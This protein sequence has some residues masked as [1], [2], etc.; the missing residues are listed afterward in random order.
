MWTLRLVGVILALS[1]SAGEASQLTGALKPVTRITL[2]PG[3]TQV[4]FRSGEP[5]ATWGW[6]RIVTV[7][8]YRS[9]QPILREFDLHAGGVST[10]LAFSIPGASIT[11]VRSGRFARGP[12]GTLAVST[13][14][15]SQDSP[16]AS[17]IAVISPD[18]RQRTIIRSS[19]YVATAVTIARDGH[20][21]AAGH[22][23][24]LAGGKDYMII[25]RFDTK[26]R[27]VS[28]LVPR[29][30]VRELPAY[31]DPS[32]PSF[33]SAGAD[34]VGWYSEATETYTEFSMDGRILGQYKTPPSTSG[35]PGL[36]I[37]DDG[38]VFVSSEHRKDGSK[39]W[40]IHALRRETRDWAYI[41]M[42]EKWGMLFGCDG[43]DLIGTT[44]FEKI[45]RF[46]ATR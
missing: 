32:S 22:E 16:S 19:P 43:K 9:G 30:T 38:G 34:R 31:V 26:G 1:S 23:G 12:D 33:L 44:E 25:R 8:A 17:I 4:Q 41:P 6:G 5:V 21:W 46:E 35:V 20:I 28:S 40:A 3:G 7:E 42:S 2:K 45:Q 29:S 39:G 18:R 14:A 36:A 11:A 15:S 10:D 24:G 13:A 37:C 27:T